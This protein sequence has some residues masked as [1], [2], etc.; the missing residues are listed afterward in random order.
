[1]LGPKFFWHEKKTNF[2]TGRCESLLILLFADGFI[3]ILKQS[4]SINM[5]YHSEKVCE[6]FTKF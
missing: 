6:W 5:P 4:V 3:P 1:M 2:Q